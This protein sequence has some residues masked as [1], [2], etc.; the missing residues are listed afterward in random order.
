M[1]R[2]KNSDSETNVEKVKS[3]LNINIAK[4]RAFFGTAC[5]FILFE[6]KLSPISVICILLMST[7]YIFQFAQN[8]FINGCKIDKYFICI[9]YISQWMVV[10]HLEDKSTGSM[11]TIYIYQS[12]QNWL[13]H[14]LY[15][16]CNEP[17][18]EVN[19]L[20][21]LDKGLTGRARP[22]W[23]PRWL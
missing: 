12:V 20:S 23:I 4:I 18:G 2:A 21:L 11:S 9:I 7:I 22:S 1:K 13:I 19:R 14:Y 3:K 6:I 15:I 10:E 8:I 16:F 5:T 17:W